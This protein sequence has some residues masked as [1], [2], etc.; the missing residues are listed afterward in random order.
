M[1]FRTGVSVAITA[2][3]LSAAALLID[4]CSAGNGATPSSATSSATPQADTGSC[5]QISFTHSGAGTNAAQVVWLDNAKYPLAVCNDGTA[6]GYVIRK[7]VGAAA[8]RWVVSLQGGNECWDDASCAYRQLTAPELTGNAV[9]KADPARAANLLSGLLSNEPRINPDFYD[10]TQV[11]ALYCSSD[12]W[13]GAKDGA[14]GFAPADTRTW[15]FRGKAIVA[16]I[17]DDLKTSQGMSTASEVLFTGESAGGVGVWAN[18]NRVAKA[19]PQR[20]RFA[21]SIDAGFANLASNFS[22]AAAG[23][24]YADATTTPNEFAERL[25]AMPLWNGSG[26]DACDAAATTALERVYCLSG[27]Q[28]LGRG[29]TISLPVLVVE[30]EKDT[31]QLLANGVSGADLS[32]G[33]YTAQ[34]T[35]YMDYFATAMRSALQST[36]AKVS[37]Y[38]PDTV[39]HTLAV[40]PALMNTAF[41]FGSGTALSLR[42][43][44]ANWYQAPCSAQRNVAQ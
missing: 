20:A 8:S 33:Q 44:Y 28:L 17:F 1:T 41:T 29:G 11:L 27:A 9:Y 15:S 6:A 16:A 37:L 21:A 24:Y 12:D 22:V 19:S 25:T 13:T 10:S 31:A 2:V 7:G 4:G 40:D 39:Q 38:A 36:N 26:D 30:S 43:A 18:V 5:A 23:P 14:G 3:F 32:S 42:E 34:E 35:A